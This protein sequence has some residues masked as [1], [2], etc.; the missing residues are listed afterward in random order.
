[1]TLGR[2][3]KFIREEH[4]FTQNEIANKI[5]VS[6][7]T[8]SSWECDRSL[9]DMDTFKQLSIIYECSIAYLTGTK[10]R[11]AGDVTLEDVL[12][13]INTLDLNDL[14]MLRTKIQANIDHKEQVMAIMQEKEALEKQLKEYQEKLKELEGE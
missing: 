14:K 7:R 8:V 6:Q 10:E 3:L 4:R 9:P 11:S 13:K 1:M 5:G 2:R 12:I